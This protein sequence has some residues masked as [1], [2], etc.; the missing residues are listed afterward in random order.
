MTGKTA[1]L[2]FPL[3]RGGVAVRVMAC[4]TVELAITFV[5]TAAPGQGRS[6]KPDCLGGTRREPEA[7]VRGAMT[8]G[9][10]AHEVWTW[11]QGRPRDGQIATTGGAL[12]VA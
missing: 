1:R 10:Q 11:G 5:V 4:H 2:I 7:S 9:A 8:F 3:R 12:V 6:L